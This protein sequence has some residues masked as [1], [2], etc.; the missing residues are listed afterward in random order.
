MLDSPAVP[1]THLFASVPTG[2]VP[3]KNKEALDG[4]NS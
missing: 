2:M 1:K 3:W 4:P